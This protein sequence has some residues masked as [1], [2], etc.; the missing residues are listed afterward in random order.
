MR[1]MLALLVLLLPHAAHAGH[2][3]VPTPEFKQQLDWIMNNVKAPDK[4]KQH[5]DAVMDSKVND[6]MEI[7]GNGN[8]KNF[9]F[10]KRTGTRPA[11]APH[12][13]K[14]LV[15]MD[16]GVSG[17]PA[18]NG[19]LQGMSGD[20]VFTP[21]NTVGFN[22]R[23]PGVPGEIFRGRAHNTRVFPN[24]GPEDDTCRVAPAKHTRTQSTSPP[25]LVILGVGALPDDAH[26]AKV[27][28]GLWDM[29]KWSR[30]K[31]VYYEDQ[32]NPCY[33]LSLAAM[34]QAQMIVIAGGGKGVL[35]DTDIARTEKPLYK[36]LRAVELGGTNRG[37][38]LVFWVGDY[39]YHGGVS[40]FVE[41]EAEDG[42][43]LRDNATVPTA[44]VVRPTVRADE[45]YV[46]TEAPQMRHRIVRDDMLDE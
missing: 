32:E 46:P 25:G 16:V 3:L 28:R 9:H 7:R 19:L 13:E 8:W 11:E 5:G 21:P 45:D 29:R 20:P 33:S 15:K 6:W 36:L 34:K 4:F 37:L 40:G 31:E 35:T 26:I 17:G 38:P 30:V 2:I 10:L 24:H 41:E 14:V 12:L 43:T 18:S 39:E 1:G 44:R 42:T 27:N 22:S 23:N